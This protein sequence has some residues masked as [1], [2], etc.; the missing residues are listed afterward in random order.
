MDWSEDTSAA[1]GPY[2]TIVLK[3]KLFFVSNLIMYRTIVCSASPKKTPVPAKTTSSSKKTPKKTRKSTPV[4]NSAEVN[5]KRR[6]I[7][8]DGEDTEEQRHI[9]VGFCL[10][11]DVDNVRCC[12]N[13]VCLVIILNMTTYWSLIV[14][15][16]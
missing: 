15:S 11:R 16:H 13:T 3:Q 7:E 1:Q 2:G 8:E 14:H 10:D 4:K 12:S 9:E 5:E 6:R